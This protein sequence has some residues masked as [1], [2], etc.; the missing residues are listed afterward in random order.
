MFK[1][2]DLGEQKKAI[3]DG[4]QAM[5]DALNSLEDINGKEFEDSKDTIVRLKDNLNLWAEEEETKDENQKKLDENQK[6][7]DAKTKSEK[8]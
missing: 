6:K 1:H 5:I 3:T 8:I 4:Y 2:D 7:L